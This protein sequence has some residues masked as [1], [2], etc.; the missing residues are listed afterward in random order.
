VPPQVLAEPLGVCDGQVGR[1]S[2]AH[3]DT[4]HR[5]GVGIRDTSVIVDVPL[6]AMLVGLKA[7][8]VVGGTVD[9]MKVA[10]TVT[11]L[12]HRLR[13]GASVRR[14]ACHASRLVSY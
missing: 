12:V 13:K 5:G 7:L 11:V 8:T 4:G 1:E 9:A 2:I 3:G 6:T 14:R 10:F